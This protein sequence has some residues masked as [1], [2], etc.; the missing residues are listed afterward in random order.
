MNPFTNA[1]HYAMPL[2][3]LVEEAEALA[4]RVDEHLKMGVQR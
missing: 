1:K 4:A 2:P 3:Q